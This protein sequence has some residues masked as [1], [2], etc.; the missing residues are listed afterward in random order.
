MQ[1]AIEQFRIN[2][3]RVRNLGSAA[4]VLDAQTTADL[5][6]SDILRS[7]LVMAVSALDQY[8]HEVVRLGMLDAYKGNRIRTQQFLRFQVSLES[9]LQGISAPANEGWLEDQIRTRHSYQSFQNYDNIADAIRLISAAQL[10]AEVSKIVGMDQRDV[11]ETLRLIVSRRN[12]IAHESDINLFHPDERWPID[13][14]TLN[15]AVNFIERIAE[16]IY[17]VVS[18]ET[19]TRYPISDSP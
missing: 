4:K 12:Q 13:E 15:E 8:V 11:R 18:E 6:V 2:I 7:E 1:T 17:S 10:W 5:D 9:A 14:L 3:I 19:L 16:A